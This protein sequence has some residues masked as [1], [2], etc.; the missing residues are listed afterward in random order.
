MDKIALAING[1]SAVA[2]LAASTMLGF[3]IPAIWTLSSDMGAA[4]TTLSS[5]DKRLE[6]I[7]AKV[8]EIGKHA[9]SIDS[10]M[11]SKETDPVN[12]I[13]QAGIR[14]ISEFG[15]IRVGTKLFV[16]PKSDKANSELADSGMKRE[17]I[18]PSTYGY[19]M[20]TYGE[21]DR[22]SPIGA[23]TGSVEAPS[24]GGRSIGPARN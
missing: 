22:L 9:D 5:I 18:T 21:N 7:E 1:V 13:A 14:P 23:A 19:V 4:K 16:L 24:T 12:L 2:M 15:G 11:T 17:N 3:T 6:K 20:G 10:R 8:D